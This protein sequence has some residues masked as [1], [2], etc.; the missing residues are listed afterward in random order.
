MGRDV[1]ISDD[2]GFAPDE[3]EFFRIALLEALAV[4]RDRIGEPE[5]EDEVLRV[6]ISTEKRQGRT[7]P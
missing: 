7:F 5:E 4:F 3:L 6:L 2:L 1:V